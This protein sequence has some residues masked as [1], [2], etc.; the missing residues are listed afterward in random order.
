MM[1]KTVHG[2]KQR[3]RTPEEK[4]REGTIITSVANKERKTLNKKTPK[5]TGIVSK[6]TPPAREQC[7]EKRRNASGRLQ[8]KKR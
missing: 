4:R 7:A 3:S 6:D 1:N 2:E 5:P 8:R